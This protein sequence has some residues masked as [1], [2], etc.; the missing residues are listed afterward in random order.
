MKLTSYGN[1]ESNGMEKGS[2]PLP[3]QWVQTIHIVVC[4]F[5]GVYFAGAERYP[6]YSRYGPIDDTRR[7]ARP[8]VGVAHNPNSIL[9]F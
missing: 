3:K 6:F 4:N 1:I 7:S 2:R 9:I 5:P 8:A